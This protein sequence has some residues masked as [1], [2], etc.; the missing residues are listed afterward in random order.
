MKDF[1]IGFFTG[2]F[3]FQFLFLVIFYFAHKRKEKEIEKV[4][5]DILEFAQAFEKDKDKVMVAETKVEA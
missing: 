3:A 1:F 5:K 2:I 4:K